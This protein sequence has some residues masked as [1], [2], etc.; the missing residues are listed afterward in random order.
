M[1]LQ[2]S[3]DMTDLNKALEIAHQVKEYADILE[4]GALLI[5]AH[6][7]TAVE[8]FSQAFPEKT[9]LADTNI[10]D[11]G[12]ES[13]ELFTHIDRSWITVMAGTPKNVIHAACAQ[14]HASGTKVMLDLIDSKE[15]GQSALEAKNLGADA[16][17]VHEAYDSDEPLVFMDKWEMIRGNTDLPIYISAHI[18]RDNIEDILRIKPNGVVIGRAIT[19]AEDP[20]AEAE[21]FH[22]LIKS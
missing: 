10:V 14:A 3:F 16:L 21:F 12:K 4:I 18:T 8:Q 22:K 15:Y 19:Q 20:K 7:V 11:H 5:Y 2:I 13:A 1:Q 17:L 6:G 9:V